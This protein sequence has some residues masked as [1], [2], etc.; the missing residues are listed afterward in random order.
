MPQK[1]SL[2]ENRTGTCQICHTPFA[3][4][5]CDQKYCSEPCRIEAKKFYVATK[6]FERE[7]RTEQNQK[8]RERYYANR[9]EVLARLKQWRA[10]N[11]ELAKQKDHDKY[12]KN[13]SKHQARVAAYRA[14][15]PLLRQNEYKNARARRPWL[16]PFQSA[17]KRALDKGL[18]FD[19]TREWCDQTYTGKCAL[20]GLEFIIGTKH[21]RPFSPSIDRIESSGGYTKDNCRF[22]LFAVNSFKGTGTDEDMLRIAKSLISL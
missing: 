14:S 19:L 15:H 2:G 5:R 7:D 4:V 9:P 10:E 3:M 21:S 12:E 20:T 6:W 18:A 22:V 11:P 13:K 8:R 1:Q 16:H 17:R